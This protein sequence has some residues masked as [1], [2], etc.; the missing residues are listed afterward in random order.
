M[1]DIQITIVGADKLAA[2]LDKLAKEIKRTMVHASREVSSEVLMT[3]GLKVYPP[4]GAA[5]R[6]PA[7][8][9][10]RGTGTIYA[11]GATNGSSETLGKQ[12]TTKT[13]G[14]NSFSIGNRASYAPYV[15]G[16]QQASFMAPKGWRKLLEVAEEKAEKITAIV[17]GFVDKLIRE[18]NL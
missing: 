10:V 6:P 16:E 9:Y 8:Y 15:H 12:W 11:S 5:N 1:P 14:D 18:N 4:A 13:L 17:Q 2:N 7:P 3:E